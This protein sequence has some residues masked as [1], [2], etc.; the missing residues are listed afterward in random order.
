MNLTFSGAK[1]GQVQPTTGTMVYCGQIGFFPDHSNDVSSVH[2]DGVLNGVGYVIFVGWPSTSSGTYTP[3]FA[4][5]SIGEFDSH[6]GA[7]GTTDEWQATGTGTL[8][9]N[10]NGGTTSGSFDVPM[11]GI[12]GSS[13]LASPAPLRMVGSFVCAG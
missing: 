5:A 11:T 12:G 7:D 9:L 8:T 4:S 13:F 2:Y 1:N 10:T 3:G 6:I